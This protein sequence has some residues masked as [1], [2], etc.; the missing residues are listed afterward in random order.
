VG[1]IKPLSAFG[2]KIH[3]SPQIFLVWKK[4]AFAVYA[5]IREASGG[6]RDE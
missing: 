5:F 4:T 6:T 1:I 3:F 2:G